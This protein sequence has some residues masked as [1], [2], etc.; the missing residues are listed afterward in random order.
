MIFANVD[1]QVIH[2]FCKAA[3]LKNRMQAQ[4]LSLAPFLIEA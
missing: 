2:R 4:Y 3:R 1:R